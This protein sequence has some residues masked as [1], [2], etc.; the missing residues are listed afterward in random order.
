MKK[1]IAGSVAVLAFIGLSQPVSAAETK[2]LVIVDSYFD[3]RAKNTEIACVAT[4]SCT[5]ATKVSTSL[6]DNTNH[7]VAMVEV[8]VKQQ[9]SI[10]II[11]LRSAPS[12]TSDVN[13]GTFIE[14]LRWVVTNK[15]R[16][17]AVSVSRYFNGTQTCTPASTNTAP[18][19][20]VANADKIIRELIVTLKGYGIPV[21]ASTGN[22]KNKAVNYPAC[23]LDTNSVSVGGVNNA[24][25]YVSKYQFDANTDYFASSTVL[26]YKSTVFGLIP[27]TTSAGTVAVAAYYTSGITLSKLVNVIP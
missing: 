14:A 8:A 21:F 13:A 5:P 22:V 27:N 10:S 17:S 3:S 24:G 16:V 18:Y 7:G 15:D 26:N 9:P 20:G 1:I 12:P 2:S 19:G 11:G 23:I 25:T 6:S 4:I